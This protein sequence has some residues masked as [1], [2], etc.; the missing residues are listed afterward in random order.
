[1]MT[2]K[3][4]SLLMSLIMISTVTIQANQPEASSGFRQASDN[5]NIVANMFLFTR[6]VQEGEWNN[7]A[8]IAAL[9]RGVPVMWL[10]RNRDSIDQRFGKGF[11]DKACLG[12]EAGFCLY[13]LWK[14]TQ[15]VKPTGLDEKERAELKAF[16][17]AQPRAAN[18]Q[19]QVPRSGSGPQVW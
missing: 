18:S 19:Q 1:M 14:L 5:V 11:V 8:V 17:D 2:I 12:L 6:L 16:R 9:G 4:S 10:T 3:V 7:Y 15:G 13:S